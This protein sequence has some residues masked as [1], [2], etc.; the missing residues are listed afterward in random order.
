MLAMDETYAMRGHEPAYSIVGQRTGITKIGQ[1]FPPQ[2]PAATNI[3]A[4][5][6]SNVRIISYFPP[7]PPPTPSIEAYE[8]RGLGW[9]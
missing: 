3:L 2:G 9:G 5:R 6:L 1:S 7:T 4:S 8:L